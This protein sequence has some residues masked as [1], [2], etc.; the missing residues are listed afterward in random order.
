[1]KFRGGKGVATAAGVIL[2][3][4]PLAFLVIAIVFMG[5]AW[6]SGYISL[7]SVV[8]ATLFPLLS[9]LL[10][11]ARG[12]VLAIEIV[13]CLFIIWKHRSNIQRLLKGTESRFRTRKRPEF[14]A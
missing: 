11:G 7:A 10:S 12:L 4:A 3:L 9:W 6:F 2:G 1:M 14:S 5:V 13:L 8:A